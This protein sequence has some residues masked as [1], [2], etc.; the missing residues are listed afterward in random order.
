MAGTR[1]HVRAHASPRSHCRPPITQRAGAHA[2]VGVRSRT[3]LLLDNTNENMAGRRVGGKYLKDITHDERVEYL[4]D[5]K[6]ED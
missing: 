2:R 3:G 1:V 4:K 6:H 5:I